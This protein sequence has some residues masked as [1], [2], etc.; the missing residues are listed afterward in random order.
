MIKRIVCLLLALAMVFGL[1]AC[2]NNPSD[3]PEFS[4][5]QEEEIVEGEEVVVENETTTTIATSFKEFGTV[6]Q[7]FL[8]VQASAKLSAV[9]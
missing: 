3:D 5:V 4:V 7:W 9:L 2:K 6:L 1:T 8:Q